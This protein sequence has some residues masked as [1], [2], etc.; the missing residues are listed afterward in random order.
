MNAASTGAN[1]FGDL[2]DLLRESVALRNTEQAVRKAAAN[3][4]ITGK[5]VEDPELAALLAAA[6]ESR[7]EP[8]EV[9]AHVR[10]Y[11]CTSCGHSW[12]AFSGWYRYDLRRGDTRS[13]RLLQTDW[14]EDLPASR[15][16]T[17]HEVTDCI[18]CLPKNLPLTDAFELPILASLGDTPETDAV[19]QMDLFDELEEEI[20]DETAIS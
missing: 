12:Q 18:E 9:F 7:W 8:S 3:R 2:N 5:A 11:C 19:F 14:H 4:R 13:A 10:N 17:E 20:E 1:A 15:V 16:D 6:E